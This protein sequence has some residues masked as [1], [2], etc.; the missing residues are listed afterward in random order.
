MSKYFND[1]EFVSKG[2]GQLPDGGMNPEL[3]ERLDALRELAGE[4]IYVTS[5]YRD[6]EHNAAIGGAPNSFHT[7]GMAADIYCDGLSIDQLADLAVDVGFRGV[8]RNDAMQYV[9][10][11]VR[12][13]QY[14]W[15]FDGS[16]EHPCDGRGNLL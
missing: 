10:V 1:S 6:P 5:G 12:P 3:I 2:N 8:E 4:P 14:F 16:N 11:D 13:D 15:R 7:R 9:H